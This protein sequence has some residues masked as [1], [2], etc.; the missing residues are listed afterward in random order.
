MSGC[1]RFQEV[2]AREA[3]LHVYAREMDRAAREAGAVI[4]YEF[5]AIRRKIELAP[6]DRLV[7]ATGARYR[8]GLGLVVPNALHLGL[9]R[10]QPLSGLLAKPALRHWFYSGARAPS[11]PRFASLARSGQN[12]TI[13]GDARRPGTAG[14]AIKDAYQAAYFPDRNRG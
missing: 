8:Y 1:P 13:I 3:P 14:D 6:F 10:R 4:K 9:G 5:D 2:A 7:I 12:M 11:G